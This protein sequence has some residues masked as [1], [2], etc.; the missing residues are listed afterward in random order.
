MPRGKKRIESNYLNKTSAD[1]GLQDNLTRATYCI[2]KETKEKIEMY[3]KSHGL[4]KHKAL[5]ILIDRGLEND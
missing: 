4:P 3:C 2:E 1:I 5:K